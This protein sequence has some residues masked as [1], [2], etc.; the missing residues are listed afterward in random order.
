[1][2]QIGKK[3]KRPGVQWFSWL[4]FHVQLGLLMPNLCSCCA[5]TPQGPEAIEMREVTRTLCVIDREN[6]S[7]PPQMVTRVVSADS[8]DAEIGSAEL[9][10]YEGFCGEHSNEE[11]VLRRFETRICPGCP[12]DLAESLVSEERLTRASLPAAYE[13]QDHQTYTVEDLIEDS[14]LCSSR[15]CVCIA[16]GGNPEECRG[17][18][19]LSESIDPMD[20]SRDVRLVLVSDDTYTASWLGTTGTGTLNLWCKSNKTTL[21]FKSPTTLTVTRT[22]YYDVFSAVKMRLDDRKPT[23]LEVTQGAPAPRPADGDIG[24]PYTYYFSSPLRLAEQMMEADQLLL[25][26]TPTASEPVILTFDLR[27]LEASVVP[28]REACGW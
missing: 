1:M 18:W 3:K 5:D 2:T 4:A 6:E 20:D 25:E 22:W 12:E 27:G 8:P 17:K 16:A 21:Y 7:A 10:R 26:F 24:D 11:V 28:L 23:R 9:V 19:Q 13:T 14:A 15:I